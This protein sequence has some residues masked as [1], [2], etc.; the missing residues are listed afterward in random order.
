MIWT[1]THVETCGQVY[2][3]IHFDLLADDLFEQWDKLY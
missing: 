1:W 3:I 2:Y